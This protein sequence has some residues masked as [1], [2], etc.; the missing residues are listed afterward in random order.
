MIKRKLWGIRA[1]EGCRR[2]W[3][4]TR[5]GWVVTAPNY[6]EALKTRQVFPYGLEDNLLECDMALDGVALWY[7]RT[8]AVKHAESANVEDYDHVKL[9]GMMTVERAP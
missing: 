4:H 8:D 9:Y 6:G 7:K 2:D 5:E 1:D 3:N